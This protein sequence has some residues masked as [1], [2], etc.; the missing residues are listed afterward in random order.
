MVS[1]RDAGRPVRL[2]D[3]RR[4]HRQH[5]R[6]CCGAV[7]RMRP[8]NPNGPVITATRPRLASGKTHWQWTFVGATAVAHLFAEPWLSFSVRGGRPVWAP[9]NTP[10]GLQDV[11]ARCSEILLYSHE[12]L[13]SNQRFRA[14][15]VTGSAALQPHDVRP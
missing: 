7:F 12:S 1:R 9:C 5:A 8:N 4:R 6:A 11:S 2:E 10:I 15:P 13:H 3:F 14:A